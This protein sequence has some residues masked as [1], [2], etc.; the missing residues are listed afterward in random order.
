VSYRHL[1]EL[2]TNIDLDLSNLDEFADNVE[3]RLGTLEAVANTNSTGIDEERIR[4]IAQAQ[5]DDADLT[6]KVE[7][8]IDNHDF[9]YTLSKLIEGY[10][11]VSSDDFDSKFHDAL[12]Y[13]NVPSRGD[14]DTLD[15][16]VEELEHRTDDGSPRNESRL[17]TLESLT[18]TLAGNLESTNIRADRLTDR[19]GQLED[20]TVRTWN[21]ADLERRLTAV[22]TDLSNLKSTTGQ[23]T[24]LLR[25]ALVL[26][27]GDR[28]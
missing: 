9:D 26:L 1:V 16:R 4:D 18:N 23:A 13:E 14:Y 6:D 7:E 2:N 21:L 27:I 11:Y 15:E 5:I 12:S 10:D 8:I 25:Q 17:G 19:V 24:D 28:S 3:D 20:N 22:E